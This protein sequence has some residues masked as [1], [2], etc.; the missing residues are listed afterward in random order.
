MDL[1][2]QLAVMSPR[3]DEMLQFASQYQQMMLLY[4]GGI[5]Q[6][7][8]KLDILNREHRLKG[9]RQP[10]ESVKSRVK[11]PKSIIRKLE[12]NGYPF[13][14]DSIRANLN[15]VAGVRVICAYISDIYAVRD[16]LLSQADVVLLKEKDYIKTPKS[17]GYRSLH[18]VVEVPVYLSESVQKVRVEVQIRTIAMDFWASLEHGLR[19][20]ASEEI[21]AGVVEELTDCA[22]IIA[23]TDQRMEQIAARLN[24][25]C[26]AA[27]PEA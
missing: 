17:N 26:A 12:R 6:I 20:K 14:L 11:E 8:T 24:Q 7:T 4:E 13:S 5:K 19:Y 15:D 25:V 1:E 2:N 18:L 22:D 16:M 21:P 3:R 9:K 23:Q 27:R 10:I